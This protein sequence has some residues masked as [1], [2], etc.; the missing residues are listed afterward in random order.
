MSEDLETSTE[1]SS[2]KGTIVRLEGQVQNIRHAYIEIRENPDETSYRSRLGADRQ[3][4][5]SA[6]NSDDTTLLKHEAGGTDLSQVCLRQE[7]SPSLIR[8]SPELLQLRMFQ[9]LI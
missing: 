5:G 8:Q 1:L 6:H 3:A 2:A 9:L 4:E 7:A